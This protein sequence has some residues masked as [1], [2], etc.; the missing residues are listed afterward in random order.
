MRRISSVLVVAVLLGVGYCGTVK[1]WNRGED[2]ERDGVEAVTGTPEDVASGEPSSEER[3]KV[4]DSGVTPAPKTDGAANERASTV[5]EKIVWGKESRGM[6]ASLRALTTG[7][8]P[9]K[10]IEF[11][12]LVKNVSNEDVGLPEGVEGEKMTACYWTIYFDQWEWK[13]GAVPSTRIAPLKPGE[14]AR[15]LCRVV[16]G[17]FAPFHHM[18]KKDATYRLPEGSY[19]VHAVF[20]ARQINRGATEKPFVGDPLQSNTIDVRII[21]RR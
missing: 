13:H 17:D 10:P 19:R 15:V 3:F 18:Q 6:V 20:D 8:E 21:D 16:A 7:A 12:I 1:S 2:H 4:T 14:T 11:E 9:G 5:E